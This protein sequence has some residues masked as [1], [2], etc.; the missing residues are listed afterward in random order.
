MKPLLIRFL[1]LLTL[2]PGLASCGTDRLE[3][4][5]RT[6]QPVQ[7][8][9]PPSPDK[10][11]EGDK[12]NNNGNENLMSKK[13]NIHINNVPFT[14][15]LEDNATV[16]AF[17][18]RLPLTLTMSDLY[19]N[20]K[21]ANLSEPLPTAA[22]R[23]GTLHAGDLMLFGSDCVVL[24]Y[25]TFQS[26]YSYTSLGRIDNPSGLATALGSGNATVVFELANNGY[27]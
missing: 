10:P 27:E 23:P 16:K 3:L 18:T 14:L 5:P 20:E 11:G 9:T 1:L 13:L 26:S 19:R 8:D 7:P 25:E 22:F 17:M 6:E 2:S 12:G 21:Y 15:T 4:P 24:F